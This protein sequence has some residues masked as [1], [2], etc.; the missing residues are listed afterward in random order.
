MCVCVCVN[1]YI[2]DEFITA[3]VKTREKSVLKAIGKEQQEPV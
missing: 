3:G 2:P 1:K